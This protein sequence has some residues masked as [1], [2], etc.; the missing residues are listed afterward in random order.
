[1][2]AE[3]T[4]PTYLRFQLATWRGSHASNN[5][6]MLERETR[7]RGGGGVGEREPPRSPRLAS[8]EPDC[9]IYNPRRAKKRKAALPYQARLPL[10][11]SMMHFKQG[12]D[13]I[14]Q[15]IL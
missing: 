5:R 1:M 10:Q 3:A 14:V 8:W 15:N 6:A 2:D 11:K 12:L 13:E 4:H 7:V 9:L